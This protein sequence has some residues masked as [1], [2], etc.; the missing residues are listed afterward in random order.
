MKKII[1][2]FLLINQFAF[3]QNF[4][5]VKSKQIRIKGSNSYYFPV[6]SPDGKNV[7]LTGQNFNGLYLYNL[8]NKKLLQISDKQGAGYK[9]VFSYDGKNIFFK[10]NENE[11]MRKVSAIYSYNTDS[12]KKKLIESE[13]R[14]VSDLQVSGGKL[15]YTVDGNMI[16]KK[17]SSSGKGDN[18][19]VIIEK[20]KIVLYNKGVKTILTPNGE[21]NYIWVSLSPDRNKI[22]YTF[23]GHGTYISDLKGNVISDLGYL[24]APVWYNNKWIAGMKDY[25]NHYNVTSSDIFVVSSDGKQTIKLTDTD[26]AEEMYP[27]CSEKNSKILYHTTDGNIY[28]LKIKQ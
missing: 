16:N 26:D 18:K 4:T 3:S 25:D 19:H 27:Y 17:N 13:K 6:L 1:I 28:Y 15:F 22:L 12:R 2:V 21:G 8:R 5:S 14:K 24:N 10:E 11:G 9:P 23:A 7:L 20:Q